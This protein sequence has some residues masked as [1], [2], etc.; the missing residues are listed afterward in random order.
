MLKEK[1]KTTPLF[2][3]MERSKMETHEVLNLPKFRIFQLLGLLFKTLI[4]IKFGK[5]SDQTKGKAWCHFFEQMGG[6]WIKVGQLIAMRTDIY[7][8][9]FTR[10]LAKLQYQAPCFPYS[11]VETIIEESM[12]KKIGMVFSEFSETPIAA[13]SLAQVHKAKIY[14]SNNYVAVKVQRPYIQELLKKDLQI[15]NM[16]FSILKNFNKTLMLEDMYNELKTTLTEEVDFRYEAMNLETAKRNFKKYKI[17]VPKVYKKLSSEKVVVMEF[18]QGVTMSEF[19]AARKDDSAILKIWLKENKVKPKKVGKFLLKSM[20]QQTFEDNYFHGDLQ[21]GN[22]MLLAKNRVALIDLGSVG[23]IDKEALN[24]YRQQMISIA[25][26]D[27]SKASDFAILATPNVPIENRH[28]IRKSITRGLKYS[29]LKSSLTEVDIDQKTTVHNTSS[30]MTKELINYG[31][32]PNWNYLKLMRT[33]TT[34]DPSIV[35][36]YP[37]IDMRRE[38]MSYF[39][40]SNLRTHKQRMLSF[41]E[42]SSNIMDFFELVSKK[43]REETIDFKMEI[44]KGTLILHYIFG[45]VKWIAIFGTAMFLYLFVQSYYFPNA[46][47]SH[48]IKSSKIRELADFIHDLPQLIRVGIFIALLLF[49]YNL[50]RLIKSLRN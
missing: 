37:K 14:G 5:A 24:L 23:T 16:F 12:G 18:I 6:M 21:P 46:E 47:I 22:I 50:I 40:Q 34:I 4:S 9:E 10:E 25:Q 43:I 33:F 29:E 36:L 49:I 41:R 30:E 26:K 45:L 13:A 38:W 2:H 35:Y 42:I 19:I 3:S 8:K 48:E 32:S 20:W 11:I 39:T 15:I 1:Y 31:V 44:T 17:Y 7:E 27:Y 28:H